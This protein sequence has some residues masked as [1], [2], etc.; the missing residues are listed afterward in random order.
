MPVPGG[1]LQ[2][3]GLSLTGL[4]GL[5]DADRDFVLGVWT[6]HFV[7]PVTCRAGCPGASGSLGIPPSV[8]V[9]VRFSQCPGFKGCCCEDLTLGRTHEAVFHL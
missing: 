6:G 7:S 2:H 1:C 3:A 9:P 5:S 4:P 8:S